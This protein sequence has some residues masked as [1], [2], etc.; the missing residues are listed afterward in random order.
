MRNTTSEDISV[1][2]TGDACPE[3]LLLYFGPVKTTNWIG[4][5]R[6]RDGILELHPVVDG[7]ISTECTIYLKRFLDNRKGSFKNSSERNRFTR[8]C[9]RKIVRWYNRNHKNVP[10]PI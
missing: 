2:N 5:A 9:V 10:E 7:V 8:K 6:L 3:Q 4:Y 1:V